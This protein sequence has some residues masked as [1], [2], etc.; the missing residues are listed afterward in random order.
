MWIRPHQLSTMTWKK[1]VLDADQQVVLY[2][3]Q[4]C[5]PLMWYLGGG[6]HHL[7]DPGC[8]VWRVGGAHTLYSGENK[9]NSSSNKGWTFLISGDLIDRIETR[10]HSTRAVK[11]VMNHM[12]AAHPKPSQ[13]SPYAADRNLTLLLCCY[14]PQLMSSVKNGHVHILSIIDLLLEWG[15]ACLLSWLSIGQ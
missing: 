6:R 9:I 7:G 8:R 13:T 4:A 3:Q 1:W 15:E 14:W 10:S 2:F 12:G 11:S 5:G